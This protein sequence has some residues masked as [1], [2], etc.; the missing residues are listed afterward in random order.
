MILYYCRIGDILHYYNIKINEF[1]ILLFHRVDDYYDPFTQPINRNNFIKIIKMLKKKY[2]I[3]SLD[4]LMFKN[5]LNKNYCSV[6]F[7]DAG[8]D[9]YNNAWPILT[10]YKIPTTLFIP[11]QN[12]DKLTLDWSM[13]FYDLIL[14]SEVNHIKFKISN[15][16]YPILLNESKH[17]K[18]IIKYHDTYIENSE[19]PLGKTVNKYINK[20]YKNKRIHFGVLSWDIIKELSKQGLDIQSHCYG[21]KNLKLLNTDEIEYELFTSYK[22]I[23]SSLGQKIY[24]VAYPYGKYNCKVVELAS[25]YYSFGFTSDNQLFRKIDLINNP[26]TI[27]R[28][29]ITDSCPYELYLRLNKFHYHIQNFIDLIW[30]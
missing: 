29:N 22:S 28:I 12:V 8:L 1:P 21:H 7:D 3:L 25:K 24:G 27:P 17:I 5:D 26:L 20:S 4:K 14:N 19:L 30:N 10:Y 23:Q 2:T 13:K 18:N 16:L 11:T 6:V 15:N 9:F